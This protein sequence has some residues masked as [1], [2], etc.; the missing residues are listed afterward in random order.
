M[1]WKQ[2]AARGRLLVGRVAGRARVGLLWRRR[3]LAGAGD[4]A[5]HDGGLVVLSRPHNPRPVVKSE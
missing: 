5:L 3:G 4:E 1:A 2:P